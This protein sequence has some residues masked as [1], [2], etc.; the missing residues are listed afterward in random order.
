MAYCV[1]CL[2]AY[3]CYQQSRGCFVQVG[4][5]EMASWYDHEGNEIDRSG[6]FYCG[7]RPAFRTIQELGMV[8]DVQYAVRCM[9]ARYTHCGETWIFLADNEWG[10]RL[11]EQVAQEHFEANPECQF[12]MVHEH[13]GWALGFR[14]DMSCY[15]TANDMAALS[16]PRPQP[17]LGVERVI[18]RGTEV[19]DATL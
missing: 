17:T 6:L 18:R 4:Q 12:V 5:G 15:S 7:D 2:P 11:M 9:N 19:S 8:D 3:I 13:A 14:R 16:K 1:I 10:N